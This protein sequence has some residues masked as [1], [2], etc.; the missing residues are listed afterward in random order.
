M[1]IDLTCPVELWRYELPTEADDVCRLL[2]YNLSD[3]DVSSL[4]VTLAGYDAQGEALSRQVERLQNV[5]GECKAAFEVGIIMEGGAQAAGME[6]IIEKVWF[7]DGTVWRRGNAHLSEYV[8]N[9][10]PNNRRLEMLRFVAGK[11]AVGY[12][13]DQG[14][15]WL[16]VCG[17]ANAASEVYCRRCQ[18]EKLLV[19]EQYN[20]VT[21]E[22]MV[23]AREQ[24]LDQIAH[25]ARLQASQQQLEREARLKRKSRRHRRV[26]LVFL[27]T[28]FT[29]GAAYGI[30]FHGI[31][32]YRYFRANQQL[33]SGLYGEAKAA[34]DQMP[35]YLDA[36][37]LVIKS[38]YLQASSD[39]KTGTEASLLS[40]QVLFDKLGDYEDSAM[41]A[42]QARYAMADKMLQAGKY[43]EAV[44]LFDQIPE[45]SDARVRRQDALFAKATAI[46]Q[47]E[48]YEEAKVIF[49]SLTGYAGADKAALECVYQPGIAALEAKEYDQAIMLLEQIAGYND[50][51]QKLLEAYYAKGELLQAAADYVAAGEFYLKA[52]NY[53]DAVTK[54]SECI[55]EPAKK[56]MEAGNF[57]RAAEMFLKI[58]GYQDSMDLASE[59]IYRVADQA[60][61]NKE[62]SRA[63]DLFLQIP[64]HMDAMDKANE[65]I[66]LPVLDLVKQS[67]F[68]EALVQAGF[69]LHESR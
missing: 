33:D 62:Y 3:K 14:A 61:A 52:G 29:L 16:C 59:C 47:Q 50:V 35:G 13:Q 56:E 1:K 65:A 9:T 20:Q 24:E 26:L 7:G 67:K 49:Q 42:M 15:L 10:L 2:L 66:Y 69:C 17:R 36:D 25:R 64:N 48:Q 40:A 55:Y 54:A 34:F 60:L 21:I 31:P 32:Y 37:A 41:M 12:P 51:D 46:M 5:K 68:E 23:A 22:E 28:V 43:D 58:K 39:L 4:Q 63:H 11:D 38:D 18:R 6:L 57:S 53:L 45:Y 19:F 44:A 27:I 8:P 30:Y